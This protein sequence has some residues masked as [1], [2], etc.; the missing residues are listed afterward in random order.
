MEFTTLKGFK[1][2]LPPESA[3][4]Q[5]I[6][7]K[8]RSQAQMLILQARLATR[9]EIAELKRKTSDELEKMVTDFQGLRNAAMAELEAQQKFTD[10]ARL[11]ALSLGGHK[12][13]DAMLDDKEKVTASSHR[14]RASKAK[15]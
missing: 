10:A 3:R 15:H 8:A 6:E 14:R 11:K 2:I 4:W 1:D 7:A 12:K 5:E 9:K 13:G